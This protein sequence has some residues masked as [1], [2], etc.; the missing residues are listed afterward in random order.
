MKLKQLEALQAVSET[1]S[2]QGAA[3][4]L[5]VTQPAISRSIIELEGELG[6]SLLTRS[7]RGATLTAIGMSILSRVRVIDREVRRI[8]EEAEASRDA[9]NGRFVIAITPPA[10]TAAL[11]DT[12]TAFSD[13]RPDVQLH[14][15]EM[16]PQ[17]I[18]SGL[19][20][21]SI[22]A[23]IFTCFGPVDSSPH[24]DIESIYELGTTLA[25]SRRYTGPLEIDIGQVRDMLWLV[26]DAMVDRNSF[27]SHLFATHH[28][29]PPS[30]ILR[31]SSVP[32]YIE[33][34][35]RLDVVSVWTDAGLSVLQKQLDAGTMKRLHL[36]EGTPGGSLC[37]AYPSVD[38]MTT[39]ARDF[40]VWLRSYFRKSERSEHITLGAG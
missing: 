18:T 29:P 38:L 28:L 4:Q 11:A 1:G 35:R 6:V 27:V 25:V 15:L 26:T 24:Y 21:G 23:A 36:K 5:N 2:L 30:R 12:I 14:V 10:A 17:Q 9:F 32:M 22:D 13:S 16:R 7:A 39:T 37:L 19:R 33:L 3:V 34:A 40:T 31:C 8:Q 20:D